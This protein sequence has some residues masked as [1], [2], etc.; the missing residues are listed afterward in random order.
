[1]SDFMCSDRG[2]DRRRLL[3]GAGAVGVTLL[4]APSRSEAAYPERPIRIVVPFAPG[5]P[6]DIMA[7]VV[8][9]HQ[10]PNAGRQQADGRHGG[11][12]FSGGGF[13]QHEER[14]ARTDGQRQDPDRVP[15]VGQGRQADGEILDRQ[16]WGGAVHFRS[17]A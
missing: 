8:A 16:H 9:A 15:T 11:H 3:K 13:G 6:T 12:G 14:L 17:P 4:V 5:G 10:D 7:R 1:M 2:L